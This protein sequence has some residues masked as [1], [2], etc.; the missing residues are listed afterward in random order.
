[1]KVFC[2]LMGGQ[3]T[4]EVLEIMM[5]FIAPEGHDGRLS[6]GCRTSGMPGKDILRHAEYTTE[7]LE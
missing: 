5:K 4:I 6:T 3:H 7:D 2:C 1:I